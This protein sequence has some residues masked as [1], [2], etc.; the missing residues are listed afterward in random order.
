MTEGDD[1]DAA[2][3]ATSGGE[4]DG[5]PDR[6][7]VNP[8]VRREDKKTLQQRRKEKLRKEKVREG[9]LFAPSRFRKEC[10]S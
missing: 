5:D 9:N 2:D 10:V 3:S 1:S 8:P 7:S 4:E 6:L